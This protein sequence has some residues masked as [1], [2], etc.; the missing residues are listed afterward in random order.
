MRFVDGSDE[1]EKGGNIYIVTEPVQPLTARIG[2]EGQQPGQGD[3]WK[4]WG[5]SRVVVRD[6]CPSTLL[7][8]RRSC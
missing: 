7:M 6:C 2:T 8:R 4:V 5:L 3:E 1:S